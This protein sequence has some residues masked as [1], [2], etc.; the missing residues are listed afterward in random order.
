MEVNSVEFFKTNPYRLQSDVEPPI[1]IGWRIINPQNCGSLLRIADT[2][3]CQKVIFV[4]G[5]NQNLSDRMIRKTS[6]TSFDRMPF[7]FISEENWED[8]IPASFKKVAV[9]TATNSKNIYQV[10]LPKNIALMVGNEKKGIPS[11]IIE[12]CDL[13][14]HI[15]LTGNCTSLNV[16]QAASVSIFEWL[17]Q[18]NFESKQK[19]I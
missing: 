11:E 14:V 8:K 17:R 16:T 3:G 18:I 1:L 4:K 6:G 15:P 19:H 10:R 2:I 9:E 7:E 12:K 5:E 13:I